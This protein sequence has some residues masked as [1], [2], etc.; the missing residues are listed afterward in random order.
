MTEQH[1][2]L[3]HL[4]T[5]KYILAFCLNSLSNLPERSKYYFMH[6]CMTLH[7]PVGKGKRADT[8][9]SS[10]TQELLFR[11]IADQIPELQLLNNVKTLGLLSATLLQLKLC[12]NNVSTMKTQSHVRSLLFRHHEQFDLFHH[13]QHHVRILL[14][15]EVT[16]QQKTVRS[17]IMSTLT[18]DKQL[19]V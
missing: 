19:N 1:F 15:A 5:I 6:F 2:P 16:K 8:K 18:G 17:H 13:S 14:L 12:S 7:I 4:V 10:Q 9:T 11:S 3:Q